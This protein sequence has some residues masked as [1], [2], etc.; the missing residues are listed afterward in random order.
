MPKNDYLLSGHVAC[1]K[2]GA[3]LVG[4]YLNHKYRYYR[5]RCNYPTA[6][7]NPMC[8]AGY[9]RAEQIEK[10]VWQEVRK[11]IEHPRLIMAELEKRADASRQGNGHIQ[12]EIARI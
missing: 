4:T 5:C 3:P 9:I 7:S 1:S 2:C 11:V 10:L 6:V 12:R 8:D